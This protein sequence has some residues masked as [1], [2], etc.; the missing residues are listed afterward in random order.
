[1]KFTSTQL[2]AIDELGMSKLIKREMWVPEHQLGYCSREKRNYAINIAND[3]GKEEVE[4]CLLLHELGHIYY[5]HMD[6]DLKQELVDVKK[7]ATSKGYDYEA[8]M[9]FYGG[10]VS[11]LNIAMD[12]EINTKLLTVDNIKTIEDGTGIQIVTRERFEITGNED[13]FRDYYIPLFEF[14]KNNNASQIAEEVKNAIKNLIK[15]LPDSGSDIDSTGD[16]EIDG[17]IRKEDYVGG[18]DKA[19]RKNKKEETNVDDYED[20]IGRSDTGEED[21]TVEITE[22]SSVEDIEKFLLSIIHMD[23]TQLYK[24]DSIKH[25]NRGSRRND[26]GLLYTATRRKAGNIRQ[27]KKL[28]IVID[29]SGS[30]E[31]KRIMDAMRSLR[32]V[33]NLIHRDSEVITCNTRVCDT[34]PITNLPDDINIGG[35]TAMDEGLKYFVEKDFTDV[36]IYSDFDT[37]I[38]AL[39][40]E[41][42]P[43]TAVYSIKVANYAISGW[44]EWKEVNKKILILAR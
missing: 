24:Q 23:R 2:R 3:T 22:G 30:M 37:D 14:A 31:T 21:K 33:F 34:F 6:I 29:I 12:L 17:L 26:N 43:R 10:P 42:S 36:V 18:N 5:G 32:E 25:Y 15:D 41:M 28:G 11:F 9:L 13:E 8:T 40:G 39:L 27:S 44:D 19:Q 35:G 4:I 38:D 1:M 16:S 20:S 7:L